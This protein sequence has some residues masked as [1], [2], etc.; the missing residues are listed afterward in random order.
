MKRIFLIAM[1]LVTLQV[2]A[3]EKKEHHKKTDKKERAERMSEYTP[4]EIAQLQ[5]KQMTLDLNLTGEQ[6]QQVMVINVENAKSRKAFME[7]RKKDMDSKEPTKEEKLKM[8]NDMLDH[9]IKMKR[10]MSEVL[11]KEQF[12]KWEV[13]AEEKMKKARHQKKQM[14]HKE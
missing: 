11:N 4:E 1:A 2:S 5:T 3:Q 8:K 10:K 14:M 13:M 12:E 7:S 6:Q 9:K